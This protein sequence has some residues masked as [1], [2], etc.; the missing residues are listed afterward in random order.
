[1]LKRHRE[2][3]TKLNNC[4]YNLL[5]LPLLVQTLETFSLG[6]FLQSF[7]AVSL[8]LIW[9]FWSKMGM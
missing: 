2:F 6:L 1:M 3:S 5:R 4:S 7:I 9:M 8:N